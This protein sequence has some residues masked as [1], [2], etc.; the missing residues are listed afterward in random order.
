MLSLRCEL[1]MV[2]FSEPRVTHTTMATVRVP[3]LPKPT[4]AINNA[5]KNQKKKTTIKEVINNHS[6]NIN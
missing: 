4:N 6:H 1:A 2:L 5:R 3:P